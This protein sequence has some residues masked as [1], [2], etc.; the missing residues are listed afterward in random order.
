MS[1]TGEDRGQKTN[2]WTNRHQRGHRLNLSIESIVLNVYI[3]KRRNV[4]SQPYKLLLQRGNEIKLTVKKGGNK[5]EK[6][7]VSDIENS[8]QNQRT[9]KLLFKKDKNI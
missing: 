5:S 9:Q 8:W 1:V 7:E 3:R 6:M 2:K 4:R